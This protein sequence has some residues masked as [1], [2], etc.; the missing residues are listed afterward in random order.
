MKYF[1][2]IGSNIEATKN[3]DSGFTEMPWISLPPVPRGVTLKDCSRLTVSPVIFMSA[4][5]DCTKRINDAGPAILA[6]LFCGLI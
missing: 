3:I 6:I 4:A 2:S 5:T 1:L